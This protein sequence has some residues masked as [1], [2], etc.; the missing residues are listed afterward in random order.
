MIN[1]QK[2]YPLKQLNTFAI[3][4]KADYFVSIKNPIELQELIDSDVF[5][6]NK[7]FILGGGSNILFNGDY[8]GLV[9][10]MEIRGMKILE[11]N[12]ENIFIESGAGESWHNLVETSLKNKFYGLE[13]LALIP[14]KVGAAPVQNIGAYGIEQNSFFHSLKGIDIESKEIKELTNEECHFTY[15]NSIFKK[16]L[17]DKFIITSVTYKLNRKEIINL[18]YKELRQEVDKFPTVKPDSQ[19]IFDTIC[20]LRKKKLPDPAEIGNAG[21]FFKNPVINIENYYLLKMQFPTIPGYN[22]NDT[23]K[24][25]SGW[26]IEQCGW[27]GK[28]F[29]DAGVSEKHALILVNYGKAT[30]SDILELAGKIEKSVNDKFG[31]ILEKEVQVI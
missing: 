20:R 5:N 15:R 24:L 2:G 19:Y 12:D 31:I 7:N 26:L 21:S 14:G 11:S 17:K 10:L 22:T 30:G 25:S 3:D 16:E 13:N 18:S 1:I 28:R 23:V 6:N 8:H 29:G 4:A 9:I 27:K